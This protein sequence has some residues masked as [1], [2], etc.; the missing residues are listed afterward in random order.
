M[1]LEVMACGALD[2]APLDQAGR[3]DQV[4]V[5]A[6]SARLHLGEDNGVVIERDEVDLSDGALIIARKNPVP[7]SAQMTR[8]DPLAVRAKQQVVRRLRR[9]SSRAA[10]APR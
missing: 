2:T 6:G 10:W 9:R 5:F 3:L 1:L 8:R 4:G 7:V